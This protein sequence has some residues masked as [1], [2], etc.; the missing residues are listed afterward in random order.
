MR[1]CMRACVC[2]LCARVC[3]CVC[4][5]VCVC[6][7]KCLCVHEVESVR[8]KHRL[9]SSVVLRDFHFISLGDCNFHYSDHMIQF[10]ILGFT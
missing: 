3:V 6:V 4:V 7:H 8:G 9:Y 10:F 1:T 2:V 5:S